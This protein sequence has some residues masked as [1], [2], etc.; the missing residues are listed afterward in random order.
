MN[1]EDSANLVIRSANGMSQVILDGV[2]VSRK[3]LSCEVYAEP[4]KVTAVL[5]FLVGDLDADL[6]N[7]DVTTESATEV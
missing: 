6:K 1:K 2:D 5:T 4:G 7:A 3:C